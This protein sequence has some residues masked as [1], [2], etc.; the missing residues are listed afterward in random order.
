M[1]RTFKKHLSEPWFTLIKLGI[2]TREGRLNKG[3]FKEMSRGDIIVYV[4]TDFGPREVRTVVT[5]KRHFSTF[6]D[7]LEKEKIRKCLPGVDSV[8]EGVKVYF[9]Y[10]S[11][12]D[13]KQH[14]VVSIHFK[15][16]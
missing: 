8:D 5:S 16:I 2:K 11:R 14:G 10:F 6:R 1:T 15:V 13:E 3:D 7:Y 4:N 9:K 12:D